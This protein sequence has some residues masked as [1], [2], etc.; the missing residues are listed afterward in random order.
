VFFFFKLKLWVGF[1]A[2]S[3]SITNLT[4]VEDFGEWHKGP[5][6]HVIIAW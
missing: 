5:E 4:N 1:V 3:N 6:K 2:P